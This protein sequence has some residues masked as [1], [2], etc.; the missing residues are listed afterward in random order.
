MSSLPPPTTESDESSR[1]AGSAVETA[2][3]HDLLVLAVRSS[4]VEPREDTAERSE[5]LATLHRRPETAVLDQAVA[6]CASG[7]AVERR[8][9]VDILGQLGLSDDACP[10]RDQS[11]PILEALLGDASA[12][13][14]EAALVALYHLG[15]HQSLDKVLALAG[16]EASGVRHGVVCALLGDSSPEAIRG[17]I[18]L[19]SDP[20]SH[21]RDWA[22]FGLGAQIEDDTPEIREALLARVCDPDPDTRAEGLAGLALR[23]DPRVL[24]PLRAALR[25]PIV[26]S[27]EVEAA[28]DLGDARLSPELESLL[29]WWDVDE[30]LLREAIERCRG[31]E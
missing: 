17:L 7:D 4:R 28:R 5:A 27:L 18:A 25:G 1:G 26:G 12:P 16:H 10:F 2:S 15:A 29:S 3:T 11:V 21:V 31:G 8:L 14:V 19:S 6:W 13:V 20:D 23:R 24:E 30:G 22:T 9:G